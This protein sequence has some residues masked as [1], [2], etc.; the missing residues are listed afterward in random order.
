MSFTV[1]AVVLCAAF[2]DAAWNAILKSR[3]D[4]L[5]S[6]TQMI[7]LLALLATPLLLFVPL[8]NWEC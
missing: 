8:P 7:M 4:R 1:V 6:V 2:F 3:G 5:S